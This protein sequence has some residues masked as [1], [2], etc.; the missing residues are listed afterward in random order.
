MRV[1]FA[2][3]ASL[4]LVP[5]GAFAREAPVAEATDSRMVLARQILDI[6]YPEAERE[7]MFRQ[8]SVQMEQQM[9]QSMGHLFDDPDILAAMKD[10]QKEVSVAQDPLLER[11]V[12]L[13]MEAW[14]RAY[15][16]I[17]SEPEL[18][19][20]LAFVSTETGKTYMVRS[21]D[22]IGNTHFAKANEAYIA[23]AFAVV[24]EKLP[25]F[26]A[27]VEELKAKKLAQ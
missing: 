21:T 15:A 1:I 17:F 27:R 19:D 2:A 20:I 7:A 13:L 9:L 23:D 4:A 3:I 8:V 10:F 24:R 12:P 26:A 6:S 5:T 14:A 25:A 11:H 18:R 16:E 22:V